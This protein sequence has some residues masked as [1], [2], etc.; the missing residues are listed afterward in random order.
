MFD[1]G[2]PELIL[3]LVV[4]LV[5]FGPGKLPEIGA[6]LGK[7][8][9]DFRGATQAI[10]NE[11]NTVKNFDILAEDEATTKRIMAEKAQAEAVNTAAAA[12]IETPAAAP[13]LAQALTPAEQIAQLEASIALQES[14]RATMGDAST[15]AI[16]A[17]IRARI[18]AIQ[19]DAAPAEV[20]V[21]SAEPAV[22]NA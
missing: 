1:V 10:S 11:V 18:E 15:D 13:A 17:T 21:P 12:S 3:V 5:V 9:R 14:L 7:A 20:S 16:I 2:V 19:R 6:S 8:I 4:A 22:V